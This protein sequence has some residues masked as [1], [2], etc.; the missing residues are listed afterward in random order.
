MGAE[1]DVMR[2][3]SSSE[4]QC[5]V[6]IAH[7]YIAK[8]SEAQEENLTLQRRLSSHADRLSQSQP[9]RGFP[10][11]SHSGKSQEQLRPLENFDAFEALVWE[12]DNKRGTSTSDDLLDATREACRSKDLAL[13]T[14]TENI[15]LKERIAELETFLEQTLARYCVAEDVKTVPIPDTGSIPAPT[16]SDSV[17]A[18]AVVLQQA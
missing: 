18:S 13:R 12:A 4:A 16:E 17:G 8:A 9:D 6:D 14:Q 3:A 7:E 15:L 11:D 5:Y 10:D 2:Y 1:L